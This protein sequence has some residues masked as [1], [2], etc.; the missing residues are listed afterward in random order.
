MADAILVKEIADTA[1]TEVKTA[2]QALMA[3]VDEA[4]AFLAGSG[5]QKGFFASSSAEGDMSG[6]SDEYIQKLKLVV[7]NDPSAKVEVT[8]H[9]DITGTEEYNMVLGLQ[10]AEFVK[11]YLVNKGISG[12]KIVTLSQGP[13]EPAATNSTREGRAANRRTEI[14]VII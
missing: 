12:E 8:G 1:D 4:R 7:D 3:S 14:K 2:E 13:K 9:T 11:S 5:V 6:V 10:R